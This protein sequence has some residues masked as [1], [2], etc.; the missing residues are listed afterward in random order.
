MTDKELNEWAEAFA[1][2]TEAEINQFRK[3][4][5]EVE[6]N[7]FSD[8]GELVSTLIFTGGVLSSENDLS[9][10]VAKLDALYQRWATDETFTNAVS[11]YIRNFPIIRKRVMEMQAALN[12]IR[13]TPELIQKLTASE[14]FL[15]DKTL[16]DLGEGMIKRYFVEDA[17]QIVLE[18]A[19]FGFSQQE[20]N[21]RYRARLLSQPDKDSYYMRYA[22]QITR[23]ATYN[24]QGQIQEA[25]A[26]EYE[27]D[28]IR[29]V[30]SIV[31]DTRPLCMHLIKDLK[32]KIK[33]SELPAI[34]KIYQNSG[35]VMPDT[36]SVNFIS[37]RGGYNCRHVAIAVRC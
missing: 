11:K 21:R 15:M 29:Y 10:I 6:R 30:G 26:E 19:Y 3:A 18:A 17:K 31:S 13:Y 14:K 9:E 12:D 23:D 33:R 1:E 27:M 34:L 28:C 16:Y 36:N 37:R 32:R 5:Q 35:G 24:Y 25:I 8:F 20:I 2:F 4:V 7:L 22:T